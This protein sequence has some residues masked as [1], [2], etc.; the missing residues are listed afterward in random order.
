LIVR[1]GLPRLEVVLWVLNS[2]FYGDVHVCEHIQNSLSLPPADGDSPDWSDCPA[3]R[4][5]SALLATNPVAAS[6]KGAHGDTSLSAMS[7]CY[8]VPIHNHHNFGPR[9]SAAS[10]SESSA[11]SA[12]GSLQGDQ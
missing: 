12:Q 6:Q 7:F 2:P 8:K 1:R 3:D 11:E 4:C 9:T 5:D 10:N